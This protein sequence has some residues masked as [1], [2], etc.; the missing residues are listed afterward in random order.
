MSLNITLGGSGGQGLV[1]AGVIFA[2]AGINEGKKVVQSQSYGPEARGGA[3]K[4][5]VILSDEEIDYPR[6]LEADLLLAMSQQA[7]DKYIHTLKEDGLLIVDSTYIKEIP[8]IPQKV[9]SLPISS[10]VRDELGNIMCASMA[11]LGAIA[12]ITGSVTKEN[13]ID[14]VV[15]RVPKG[16]DKLNSDAVELGYSM[17]TE[18]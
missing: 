2:Q 11:A 9:I 1:L 4:S 13:L 12:A 7:L 8:D 15:A 3:S 10:S 6:V 18:Q 16:T 17:G 14:A 5:D